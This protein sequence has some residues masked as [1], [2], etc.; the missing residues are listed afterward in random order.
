MT[1]RELI[2]KI[3]D[4]GVDKEIFVATARPETGCIVS[5]P[6]SIECCQVAPVDDDVNSRPVIL[7]IAPKTE[8][9]AIN[10][11]A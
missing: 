4:I 5:Q 11:K 1:G 8:L 6:V 9:A 3:I 10:K 7:I 2:Q